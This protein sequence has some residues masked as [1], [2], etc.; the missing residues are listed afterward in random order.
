M[1][2]TATGG[3]P[4]DATT[5]TNSPVRAVPEVVRRASA[6]A[7]RPGLSSEVRFRIAPEEPVFAG[8]YPDF[9]IFPG[10]CVVE[11]AHRAALATAPGAGTIELRALE[12]ARFIGPVFPG[13]VLTVRADWKPADGGWT[14]TA[15]AATE[16][17]TSAKVR[18]GFRTEVTP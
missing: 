2:G 11:C 13:D 8:H 10:V 7:G 6:D 3:T 15:T 4:T 17:G 14:Y 18:L 12:S 1:T 9:P 5:S 16:R